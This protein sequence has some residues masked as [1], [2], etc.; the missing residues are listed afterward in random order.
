MHVRCDDGS[1]ALHRVQRLER[2]YGHG[3]MSLILH[4]SAYA[5][6]ETGSQGSALESVAGYKKDGTSDVSEAHGAT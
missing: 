3:L 2:R 4:Y 1:T 5:R 6:G